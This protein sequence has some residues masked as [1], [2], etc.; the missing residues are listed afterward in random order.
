MPQPV[1]HSALIAFIT[2]WIG[3]LAVPKGEPSLVAVKL[4]PLP[5]MMKCGGCAC[6]CA[7]VK[8][9]AMAKNKL[10]AFGVLFIEYSCGC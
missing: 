3:W 4:V 5:V 8:H 7:A 6:A 1:P 2:V 9:S 10:I